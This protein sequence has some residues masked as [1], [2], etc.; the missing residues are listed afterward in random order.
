MRANLEP[1]FSLRQGRACSAAGV[2]IAD[3]IEHHVDAIV[4]VRW[5]SRNLP[6]TVMTDGG[7][8]RHLLA[9]RAS[10]SDVEIGAAFRQNP[11]AM[12]RRTAITAMDAYLSNPQMLLCAGTFPEVCGNA[13]LAPTAL[14]GTFILFGDF[15]AK[16]GQPDAARQ[17]YRFGAPFESGWRFAGLYGDRLATVDARIAAY[18]D[19]DPTND[20]SIVG[21]GAQACA[22]CHNRGV[23]AP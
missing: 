11:P 19:D 9:V 3:G 16:A 1:V 18:R 20:P 15:Y 6:T 22:S 8:S 12:I 4:L 5:A 2:R 10:C 17:W 7:W 13:G 21:S 23:S 14:Q